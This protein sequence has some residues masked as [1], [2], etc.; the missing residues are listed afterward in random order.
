MNRKKPTKLHAEPP[1][2][3]QFLETC[4]VGMAMA[5]AGHALAAEH[6]DGATRY[7]PAT[8][9][10]T[11]GRPLGC[12]DL[13]VNREYIFHYPFR[14]TPCFLIDLGEA[15]DGGLAMH[16]ANGARYT[17]RGGIGSRK[18]VVA[19]SAICAHKLSHPSPEVSF[20]GYRERPVG[21]YNR[22]KDAIERRSGVIQC[23]SEQSLY[24]PAQ[25]AQ[26]LSG[27]A[28][29]PLAAIELRET[30]G[31]LQ[32]IGVYGGALFEQYFERFGNRLMITHR[33]ESYA[34]P[35][36]QETQVVPGDQYTRNRISCG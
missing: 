11:T 12:D 2:R 4:S 13:E 25:G 8:L 32:A 22:S 17:W 23:C 15:R 26:V 30:D 14:S 20:I 9:V 18:S 27:P 28:P 33:G 21:F 19:F 5:C 35:V 10:D 24:D 6:P 29:Q 1:P 31:K 16:T 36:E 34:L 7:E 3:R